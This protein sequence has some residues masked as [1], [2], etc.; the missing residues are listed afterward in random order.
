MPSWVGYKGEN[1]IEVL[2]RCF[3]R[4]QKVAKKIQEWAEKFQIP[5]LRAGYVGE[6]KLE[7]NFVDPQYDTSL[8]AAL[9]GLGSRQIL[10]IIVQIFAAEPGSVIMVEEPEISVHP[11]SQVLL[12]ELFATAI[13]EG[14]QIICTTHSPFLIL[15]INRIIKKGLAK[16]DSIAIYHVEKGEE[17]TKAT[18]L[19][20]NKHGFLENGIPSFMKTEQ[21]LFNEWSETLEEE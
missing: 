14:K 21:Q 18:Q 6:G 3:T 10:P 20:L 19:P 7:T 5:E 16:V 1:V 11:E 15:A 2:S 8:N 9:A 17:G 4:E 12:D 13:S